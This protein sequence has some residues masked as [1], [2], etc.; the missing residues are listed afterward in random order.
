L[1]V[2]ASQIGIPSLAA[3]DSDEQRT[4]ENNGIINSGI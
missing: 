3:V 4:P 1:N 2:P